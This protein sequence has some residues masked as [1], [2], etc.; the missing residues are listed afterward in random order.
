M[1]RNPPII[2][3]EPQN[4]QRPGLEISL[5]ETT[6]GFES[7]SLRQNFV[8]SYNNCRHFSF[9]FICFD[10]VFGWFRNHDWFACNFVLSKKGRI[11]ERTVF[12]TE[13]FC[14]LRIE[15]FLY[16]SVRLFDLFRDSQ[17]FHHG[18]GGVQLRRI[19]QMRVDVRRG[20]EV[21]VTEPFLDLLE[22][23]TVL[24]K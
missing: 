21:A 24:Q 5:W 9:V 16:P 23:H 18:S 22:L 7:L 3:S 2:T 19:I 8:G 14:I 17:T 11:Q 1:S 6:R 12:G 13:I 15:S 10:G 20:G 4:Y